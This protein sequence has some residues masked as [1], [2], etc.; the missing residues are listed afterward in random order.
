MEQNKENISLL[1]ICY[2]NS[3]INRLHYAENPI[4]ILNF[5]L[6]KIIMDYSNNLHFQK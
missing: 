1:S 3:S 4:F 6:Y 5:L 2:S